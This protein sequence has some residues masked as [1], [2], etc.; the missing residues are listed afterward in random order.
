VEGVF[1]TEI[2]TANVPDRLMPLDCHFLDMLVKNC[3]F[4][5]SRSYIMHM[6][7]RQLNNIALLVL[8]FLR[9]VLL[10]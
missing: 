3:E 7:A 1:G 8:P 5:F 2:G 9:F 4:Q 10:E 6:R